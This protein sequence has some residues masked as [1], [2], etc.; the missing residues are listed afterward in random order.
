MAHHARRSGADEIVAQSGFV[1]GDHDK[2]GIA[3]FG[4]LHDLA[5]CR[6]IAHILDHAQPGGR[7]CQRLEF[8]HGF[9]AAAFLRVARQ[10]CRDETGHFFKDVNKAHF[11]ARIQKG[12]GPFDQGFRL[13]N[14]FQIH[15]DNYSAIHL[16]FLHNP[17]ALCVV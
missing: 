6:A 10:L 14:M 9:G 13:I 11:P 7:I 15:S 17:V 8:H 12:S 5:R 2:V 3:V 1:T 4:G 16:C